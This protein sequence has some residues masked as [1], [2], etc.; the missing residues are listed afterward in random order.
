VSGQATL[1]HAAGDVLRTWTRPLVRRL[2]IERCPGRI[3]TLHNLK[4]PANVRPNARESTDGSSNIRIIFRLLERC[5]A[6]PGDLAECGVWQGSTLIP[7]ALFV[8]RRA[9]DKRVL[10]FDS[11]QGLNHTVAHDA[12]LDGDHDDRK[13]VGGFSD[14]SY[15]AVRERVRHF[16]VADTVTLVPGYFQD[17]LRRHADARFCFVHLDC[18]IYDSY[19][20]CLEFFYPRMNKGG[21]ILIDEYNDPPWPG[22]T[23]AVDE[24]LAGKPEAITEVKSDNQIRYYV[25]KR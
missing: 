20:E 8:R 16:D 18:V 6:L 9:P 13:R 17:T 25:R 4:V 23:Q 1:R 3:A 15:A 14:T 10:G 7:T 22:C 2:P 21:I 5:L 19:K 11:F 12:A 24:F